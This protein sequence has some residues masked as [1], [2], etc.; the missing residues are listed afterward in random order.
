[1]KVHHKKLKAQNRNLSKKLENKKADLEKMIVKQIRKSS[2]QG[3]QKRPQK[4]LKRCQSFKMVRGMSASSH[5]TNQS[6]KISN[7][8]IP[9]PPSIKEIIRAD[10]PSFGETVLESDLYKTLAS[11]ETRMSHREN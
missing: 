10:T 9:N 2:K 1:M 4:I 6:T 7:S 5:Y 11:G 3:R 8:I